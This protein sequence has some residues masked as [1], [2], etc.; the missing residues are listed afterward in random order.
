MNLYTSDPGEHDKVFRNAYGPIPL[1]AK[2]FQNQRYGYEAPKEI[3]GW[4]WSTTFGRWSALVTFHNGW[5]GFTYP[6]PNWFSECVSE[7]CSD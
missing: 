6:R 4:Q 5:H 1:D 3:H 7:G 2:E